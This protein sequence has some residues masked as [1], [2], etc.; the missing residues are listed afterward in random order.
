MDHVDALVTAGGRG[1]RMRD[2]PGE[3]PIV[4]LLGRPM[5][6]H[7]LGALRQASGVGRLHVSVSDNVPMTERHLRDAGVEVVPTSGAGYVAD[8]QE[9][10]AHVRS[11]HVLICPADMPLLTANGIESVLSYFKRADVE[12]LSVA[13]PAVIV[14]TVGAVPSYTLEVDGREVVVCGVSIV[15][16]ET[17]LSGATLSQGFMVTEDV[18]FALNVNT[19]EEL[20]RAEGMLRKQR[21][22]RAYR[23]VSGASVTHE[24]SR[25]GLDKL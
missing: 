23:L 7:V 12:S 17:M 19:R 21:A 15:H 20:A 1:S 18:Q 6:D 13:V 16:R 4:P 22:G 10:L 8:L 2:V 5:I 25:R 3:K 9:A 11:E 24:R 14:R